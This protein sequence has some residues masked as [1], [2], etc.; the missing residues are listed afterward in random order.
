MLFHVA[1]P[2]S[3]GFWLYL[4]S[5]AGHHGANE[6]NTIFCVCHL[7]LSVFSVFRAK[8]Y[9]RLFAGPRWDT[10]LIIQTLPAAYNNLRILPPGY[11]ERMA[12]IHDPDN[13]NR[14]SLAFLF[15]L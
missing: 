6:N 1:L 13:R 2:V 5:F 3:C 11:N 4:Q 10:P 12:R 15:W 14:R 8:I 7:D 9:L